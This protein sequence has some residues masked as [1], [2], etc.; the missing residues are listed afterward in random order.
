[1]DIKWIISDLDGT[2]IDH[3]GTHFRIAEDSINAL[4]KAS[5]NGKYNV[6]IA[7][8][9]HCADVCDILKRYKIE[10]P[11][12]SYVIG[13]NGSHIY[14]YDNKEVIYE[15]KLSDQAKVL[16]DTKLRDYLEEKH[17]NK[18]L[19]LIYGVNNEIIFL[20]SKSGDNYKQYIEELKRY[21][22]L[23]EDVFKV[24]EADSLES[25]KGVYKA[26]VQIKDPFE[27]EELKKDFYDIVPGINILKT[28]DDAVELVCQDVDKY[29]A[30]KYL[31]EKFYNIKDGEI[32]A[33]G[34]SFNDLEMLKHAGIS[35]TRESANPIIKEACTHVIDAPASDFVGDG[36]EMLL[37]I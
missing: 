10:L 9:R 2:L 7:T 13:L 30:I 27:L 25:V 3:E 12:K 5:S 29:N 20:R 4:N 18:Y 33:F 22:S 14:D 19:I 23:H 36:L 11:K 15:Q 31:Q 37:D 16:I 34:D 21:E 17:P 26:I 24:Y 6:T 35:V 32:I 28:L 1:M 8:G